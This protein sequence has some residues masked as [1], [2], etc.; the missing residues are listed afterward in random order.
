M[1]DICFHTYYA[2]DIVL[3]TLPTLLPFNLHNIYKAFRAAPGI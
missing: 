1:T 3:D 2:L